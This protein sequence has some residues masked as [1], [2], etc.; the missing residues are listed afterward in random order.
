MSRATKPAILGALAV[1]LLAGCDYSEIVTF[2]DEHG[3]ACTVVAVVDQGDQTP[4]R[5][6]SGIDCDYPPTGQSPGPVTAKPLSEQ[7]AQ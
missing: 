6:A 5:E 2:T 1:T 7:P 3:R 4:E